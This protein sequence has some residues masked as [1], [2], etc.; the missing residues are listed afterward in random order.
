MR[1]WR[2]GYIIEPSDVFQINT[3]IRM[4]ISVLLLNPP[5][6]YIGVSHLPKTCSKIIKENFGLHGHSDMILLE[7]P[8]DTPLGDRHNIYYL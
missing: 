4:I 7:K 3:G 1:C 8:F 2:C 6:L 5:S